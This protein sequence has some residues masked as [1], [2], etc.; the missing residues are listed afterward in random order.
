MIGPFLSKQK[1]NQND[2][3][4][5][6]YILFKI[7]KFKILNRKTKSLRLKLETDNQK[8]Q[9]NKKEKY[10]RAVYQ[11]ESVFNFIF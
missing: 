11:I 5:S 1:T 6:L 9:M 3:I 4:F 10:Q 8:L 2:F 7:G